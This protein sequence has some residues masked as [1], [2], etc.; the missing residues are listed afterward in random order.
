[1]AP[2]RHPNPPETVYRWVGL[3]ERRSLPGSGWLP[4][5]PGPLPGRVMNKELVGRKPTR[6]RRR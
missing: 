5:A 2:A 1:M 6:E 3:V 4:L